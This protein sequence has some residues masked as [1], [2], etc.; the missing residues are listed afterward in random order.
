[1]NS[2]CKQS[3]YHN[4]VVLLH[5]IYY[6]HANYHRHSTKHT[7]MKYKWIKIQSTQNN[8]VPLIMT[9]WTKTKTFFCALIINI[10]RLNKEISTKDINHSMI[11]AYKIF[12]RLEHNAFVIHIR[13]YFEKCSLRRKRKKKVFSIHKFIAIVFCIEYNENAF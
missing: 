4:L 7:K 2:S 10:W 8:N 5:W 1:M 12:Y 9:K 11:K 6:T 3:N 13:S